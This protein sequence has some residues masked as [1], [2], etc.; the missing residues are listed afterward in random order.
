[1]T[2]VRRLLTCEVDQAVDAGFVLLGVSAFDHVLTE[3][4]CAE[5]PFFFHRQA[6]ERGLEPAFLAVERRFVTVLEGLAKGGVALV[7][8]PAR[9]KPLSPGVSRYRAFVRR[10]LRE[11]ITSDLYFPGFGARWV[12]GYDLT[13]WV[14]LPAADRVEEVRAL[15]ATAGLH[16]HVEEGVA[17]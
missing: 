13:H 10:S 11:K 15:V 12:F 7:H 3:A 5:V 4:E 6:R 1:M 9:L 14:I 2:H 17:P 8:R 16:I